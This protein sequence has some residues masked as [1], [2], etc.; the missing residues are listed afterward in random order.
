MAFAI[1]ARKHDLDDR[2][3]GILNR[4]TSRKVSPAD[5]ALLEQVKNND[6]I[7]RILGTKLANMEVKVR[8]DYGIDSSLDDSG[9]SLGDESSQAEA[10]QT[11]VARK[12]TQQQ[13]G[14]SPVKGERKGS[15]KRQR[16]VSEVR[17]DAGQITGL[18]D[19]ETARV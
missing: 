18:N 17:Q 9:I 15:G 12:R 11:R 16:S 4:W 1:H 3:S 10:A 7:D 5:V 8:L 19:G 13:L 14:P 2:V 6:D